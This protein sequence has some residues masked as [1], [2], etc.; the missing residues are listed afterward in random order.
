MEA[1]NHLGGRVV[2]VTAGRGRD[3]G[4]RGLEVG[5]VHLAGVEGGGGGQRGGWRVAEGGGGVG[6]ATAVGRGGRGQGN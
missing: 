3:D 5:R 4:A 1:S 6:A 2:G